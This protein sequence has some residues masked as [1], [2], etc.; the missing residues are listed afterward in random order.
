MPRTRHNSIR[1]PTQNDIARQAGVSTA[2]VS[3]VL[4]GTAHVSD[5]VKVR[6]KNT[7]AEM[8][9]YPH[10]AARALAS[11]RS[12]TIGA[13]IPTLDSAIFAAGINA[14]EHRLNAAGQTLLAAVSSYSQDLEKT[15]VRRFLERGVDALLLVGNA[16][17]PEI[18][19]MIKSA[20]KPFVNTWTH[21][22]EYGQPNIGFSN[23]ETAFQIAQHVHSQGHRKIAML[24]GPTEGNDRASERVKGVQ[25]GLHASGLAIVAGG[26]L[27][28]AYELSASRKAASQILALTPRPT[29]IICGND[30][31]AIG[32][33][34]E[35]QARGLVVGNDVSITGFDDLP[36]TAHLPPGITT[37]NVQAELMGQIA[38]DNI[39]QALDMGLAVESVK[40][41]APL[42]IRGST[43]P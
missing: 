9:Y 21:N 17:D 38:A 13:I 24:A 11:N 18:Y 4:N 36:L 32:A 22:M 37:A 15:L 35:S 8:G 39:L 12:Q 3:R 41:N 19:D 33:V 40:L 29:A 20:G 30:V 23:Y 5:D 43:A 25:N 34:L 1:R 31:I 6:I 14:F 27:E 16:R 2:T 28:V 10:G 26:Y 42:I 7:V